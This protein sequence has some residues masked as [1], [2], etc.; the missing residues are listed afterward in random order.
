MPTL[1]EVVEQ[2]LERGEFEL[3]KGCDRGHA[4]VVHLLDV[5]EARGHEWLDV[6]LKA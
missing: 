3:V 4:S 2:L 5:E 6:A 1:L